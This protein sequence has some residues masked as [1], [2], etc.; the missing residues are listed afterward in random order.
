M[1]KITKE[2]IE[3]TLTSAPTMGLIGSYNDLA[4][5]LEAE[6][7]V[8]TEKEFISNQGVQFNIGK[9]HDGKYLSLGF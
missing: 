3:K 1:T 8:K 9:T 2:F 6:Y 4:H 5:F 7:D